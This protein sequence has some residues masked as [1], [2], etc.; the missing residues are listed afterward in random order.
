MAKLEIG[1]IG[2]GIGGVMASIAMASAG[3]KVT[4][5]EAAEELGDIGTHLNPTSGSDDWLPSTNEPFAGAGIQMVRS[6]HRL[7]TV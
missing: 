4:V 5:L 6:G 3:I 1:I 2:A 7:Q